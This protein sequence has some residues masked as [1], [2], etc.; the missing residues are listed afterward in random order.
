MAH[1]STDLP[2]GVDPRV[3]G[4]AMLQAAQAA[5]VGVTITLLEPGR[6]RNIY[7]SDAAADILGW[8][9]EDLLSGDAYARIAPEDAGQMAAR[10]NRRVAGDQGPSTYELT[11]IRKDGRRTSFEVTATS[12]SVNGQPAAVAFLVDI[13]AR[14][15]AQQA[16]LRTEARFRGLIERAPEPIGIIRDGAF[17]YANPAFIASLGYPSAQALYAV[18][19]AALLGPADLEQMQTR[20]NFI[21][22]EG[23]PPPHAYTVRRYDGSTMLLETSSVPF[24]YE[25]KPSVLTMGRTGSPRSGRWLPVWRTRSTTRSHT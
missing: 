20:F 23:R 7:V 8:P 19:L 22:A 14:K 4:H 21:L 9:I 5:G 10:L 25:G 6:A 16:T 15:A 12:V 11:A 18:S 3:V 13:T 2:P 24:E 17:V 1:P